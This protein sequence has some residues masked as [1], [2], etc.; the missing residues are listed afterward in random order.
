MK[1]S[2][3][4]T[5]KKIAREPLPLGLVMLAGSMMERD[6][7]EMRNA[8]VA[9]RKALQLSAVESAED[10]QAHLEAYIVEYAEKRGPYKSSVKRALAVDPG[11]IDVSRAH[12]KHPSARVLPFNANHPA[13][14]P[15]GYVSRKVHP[16][17]AEWLGGW[18]TL[19]E[20]Y[21][22]ATRRLICLAISTV[23]SRKAAAE[24]SA[25]TN[26]SKPV[27]TID[28]DADRPCA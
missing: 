11:N 22:A 5:K 23:A 20:A 7:A 14:A 28:C 17:D 3:R 16:V 19:P 8:L 9:A 4:R 26:T 25:P 21:R 24:Q 15:A 1:K 2:T 12:S 6:H 18:Y 13:V 10:G 27:V